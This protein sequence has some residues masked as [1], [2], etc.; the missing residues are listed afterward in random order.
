MNGE[1]RPYVV[2][3]GDYLTRLAHRFGFDAEEVWNDPKNAEIKKLRS[4]ME[5]LAPGD[6]VYLPEPTRATLPIQKGTTNRYVATIPK[7]END[8][9]VPGR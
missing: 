4:S 1:L 2:R 8:V 3:Q 5:V 9:P 6:I 7:V